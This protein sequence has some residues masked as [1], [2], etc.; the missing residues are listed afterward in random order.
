[1]KRSTWQRP[2]IRPAALA[3]FARNFLVW[4]KLLGP[5]IVLNFG[6][7]IIYLLGLG[8]GLGALVGDVGGLPYLVFL[9][10]GIVASSA[11]VSVSFEGMYSVY[12]R[13]VPQK[14]FDAI[15]ATPLDV[16]DIV[17]GET[18]WAAFK[19]LLSAVAILTVAGLLGAVPGGFGAIWAL[20]VVFLLGLTFAGPAIIMSAVADNYDFFTY[21][22]VLVVTPMFMLSGVFFP[23]ETL[24][25]WM[26]T[27]VLILPLTHA[28]EVIRPLVVG[29]PVDGL[30]IHL[31]VLAAFAVA[32]Y[33]IAVALVRRRM[34]D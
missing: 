14:T 20:P 18:V 25:G 16:D 31:A 4:R 3:V 22:F 10:S 17:L 5:A 6:E 11:M 27:A 21:Y 24:P 32:A 23:L 1:M 9:A 28:I 15:L 19:G 7:P 12:T 13:M 26:Q 2:G 29:E 8:I 30:F 34:W 33:Y